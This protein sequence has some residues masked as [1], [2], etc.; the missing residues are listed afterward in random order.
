M[1]FQY[2]AGSPS[3]GIEITASAVRLAALTVRGSGISVEYTKIEELPAG[4]VCGSYA[5]PNIQDPSGLGAALREGLSGASRT[6]RRA[7]LA[8]PDGVFRVQT[9]EFDELPAKPADRERLIRWRLE[10]AAAFDLADTVLRFQVLKRP[11]NG[12][13]ALACV[14]K[15]SVIAQYEALL[16]ELGLEPWNVGVSSFH[17]LNLYSPFLSKKSPVFAIAHLMEDS[18]T[19]IVEDGSGTRF[20]RYKDVKRAAADELKARFMREIEDSLHFYAHMDRTQTS[21]VQHL[22]LSGESALLYDLRD[23]LS[24]STPLTVEVLSPADIITRT[25]QAGTASAWLVVMAAALGAGSAL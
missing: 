25:G 19:T 7:A 13:V 16:T 4:T 22:Y 20:Y 5:S 6:Y 9:L 15:Q 14:A 3:L 23:G 18:F 8:L 17:V 24:T 10:K 21:V 11:G 2:F 12:Y 1:M